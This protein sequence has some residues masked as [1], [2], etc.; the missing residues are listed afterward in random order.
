[1]IKAVL[2]DTFGTIVDWRSSVAREG[3]AFAKAN[4]VK[5]FDGDGFARHGVRVTDQAWH[6]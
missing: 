5:G 3:E 6:V 4:G 2:F 1:M